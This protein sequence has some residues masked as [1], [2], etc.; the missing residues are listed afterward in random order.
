MT[1]TETNTNDA[2]TPDFLA[3]AASALSAQL[4]IALANN[5]KQSAHWGLK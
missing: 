3:G 2:H 4:S 5:V 1:F